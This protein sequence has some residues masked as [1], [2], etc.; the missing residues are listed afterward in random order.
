MLH[1]ECGCREPPAIPFLATKRSQT[2]LVHADVRHMTTLL[3]NLCFLVTL[4]SS[5]DKSLFQALIVMAYFMD[6]QVKFI[7]ETD[8][9]VIDG[10]WRSASNGKFGYS[11]QKELWVQNRRYWERLFKAIDWTHGVHN[12][13]RCLL[14]S[15]HDECALQPHASRLIPGLGFLL[16]DAG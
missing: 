2:N 5:H 13:Y 1:G 7:P 3:N 11:V 8:L 12:Y 16:G 6:L 15:L 14:A 10:L 4:I 9:R